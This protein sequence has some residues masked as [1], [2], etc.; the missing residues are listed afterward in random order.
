MYIILE[1]TSRIPWQLKQNFI[2]KWL[3]T[4]FLFLL[5]DRPLLALHYDV[6]LKSKVTFSPN[7]PNN[8]INTACIDVVSVSNTS[9]LK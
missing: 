4:P 6:C 9:R 1:A 2:L 3:L 7:P 5:R 8:F